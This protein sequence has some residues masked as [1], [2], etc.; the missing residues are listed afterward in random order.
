MAEAKLELVQELPASAV[1]PAKALAELLVA[2]LS[3]A[4]LTLTTAESCTAGALAHLISEAPGA[5]RV[6]EGGLVAYSKPAKERLL[7]VQPELLADFTAVSEPVA[8]AMAT[9]AL[10]RSQSD[11]A[12]ALTGVTGSEPDEDGNPIG[13]VHIA[14]AMPNGGRLHRHCEFGAV[15]SSVLV[16]AALQSALLVALDL[17]ASHESV[18]D[19][20]R[21]R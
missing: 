15:S 6:L 17:L 12:I 20:E 14:A 18:P 13:R 3:E 16:H 8:R 9:G 4:H 5:S 10:E 11:L 1:P 19:F 7:G 2:K 21:T